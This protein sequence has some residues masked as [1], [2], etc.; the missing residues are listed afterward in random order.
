MCTAQGAATS[1]DSYD[2]TIS[3]GDAA[4]FFTLSASQ[5][6]MID[7]SGSLA[8]A[9]G[10]E[11]YVVGGVG[12]VFSVWKVGQTGFIYSASS[13]ADPNYAAGDPWETIVRLD[14]APGTYGYSMGATCDTGYLQND[15]HWCGAP[16]GAGGRPLLNPYPGT[17]QA[18]YR[19]R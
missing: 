14:L 6:V 2:C 11:I 9:H 4:Q 7:A 15:A 1:G 17:W 5:S 3:G 19:F 16:I 18:L 8:D 10:N 13:T 12:Y